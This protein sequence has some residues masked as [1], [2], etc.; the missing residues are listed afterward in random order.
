[1]NTLVEHDGGAL[2]G[3][4]VLPVIV[5]GVHRGAAEHAGNGAGSVGTVIGNA[6]PGGGGTNVTG[7][8][9]CQEGLDAHKLQK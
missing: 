8:V 1:M 4:T 7:V 9:V 3:D 6:T 2:P 5:R